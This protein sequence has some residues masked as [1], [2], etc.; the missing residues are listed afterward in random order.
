MTETVNPITTL[1]D[2]TTKT[3]KANLTVRNYSLASLVLGLI[4]VPLVDL[5]ALVVLQLKLLHSLANQYNIPFSKDIGKSAIIALIGGVLPVEAAF[6]LA[7][8]IKI[9][10]GIGQVAGGVSIAMLGA[11]ATYAVGKVFIQHFESGGTFLTFDPE[12]VRKYFAEEFEKGKQVAA[13]LKEGT[14]A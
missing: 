3:K 6:P 2:Y 14:S 10:P 1:F 12:K 7:S 11:A 4:P 9:I 13:E 8:L 5:A